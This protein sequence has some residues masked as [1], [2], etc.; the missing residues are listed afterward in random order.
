MASY[1]ASDSLLTPTTLGDF[2]VLLGGNGADRFEL[3]E[4]IVT[5]NEGDSLEGK[6]EQIGLNFAVV[7][8]GGTPDHVVTPVSVDPGVGPSNSGVFNVG[9]FS[10]EPT[11]PEDKFV[12]GVHSFGE[13]RWMA[14]S[15]QYV[16]RW[17]RMGI[18]TD[19]S[20]TGLDFSV[21]FFWD[22]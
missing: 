3:S 6:D 9:P 11:N 18:R 1:T 15:R 4:F 13:F 14:T 22:E 8:S 16:I 10:V 7:A 17:T 20:T 21:T 2:L 12:F 19:I 5:G